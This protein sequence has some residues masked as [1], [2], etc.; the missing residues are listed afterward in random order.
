VIR[1]TERE[2]PLDGAGAASVERN[3]A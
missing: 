1:R 2:L 3:R